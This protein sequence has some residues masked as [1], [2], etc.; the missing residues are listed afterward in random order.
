[1]FGRAAPLRG[2]AN[3][4]CEP[5]LPNMPSS[6]FRASSIAL[7]SD[8]SLAK[9]TVD[10]ERGEGR[11]LATSPWLWF[12]TGACLHLS[13]A[14]ISET[15]VLPDFLNSCEIKSGSGRPG[16]EV[17]WVVGGSL[18]PTVDTCSSLTWSVPP[19]LTAAPSGSADPPPPS[20]ASHGSPA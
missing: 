13:R 15:N 11:R 8:T 4:S 10:L 14:E 18:Q 20:S 5:E 1:M 12:Y 17:N 19:S 9:S 6:L 7:V 2:G 16:Y 3:R